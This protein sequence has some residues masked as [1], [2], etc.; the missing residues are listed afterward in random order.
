MKSVKTRYG[1]IAAVALSCLTAGCSEDISDSGWTPSLEGRY[2]HLAQRDF[3]FSSNEE[4]QT[5]HIQSLND[6]SFSGLPTWLSLS[7][8]SGH[9]NSDFQITAQANNSTVTSREAVFYVSTNATDKLQRSLTATQAG[10]SPY[11]SVSS[12]TI[13]VAGKGGKEVVLVETNIPSLTTT[14]SQ[15]WATASYNEGTRAV[16]LNITANSTSSSRSG[17]LT[18][19]SPT[20]NLTSRLT[21]TQLAADVTIMEGGN[22]KYTANGGSQTRTIS[23]DLPWTATSTDSWIEFSPKS[24]DAGETTMTIA[25]LPSYESKERVGKIDLYFGDTKRKY[26]GITQDGRYINLTPS[27]VTVKA[28][29]ETSAS[30]EVDA[31]IDWSVASCPDWLTITPQNGAAGKSKITVSAAENRSLNSRSSTIRLS[32]VNGVVQATASVEQEGLDFGD[33]TT[34]EF[35]WKSSQQELSIPIPS[36]WN[37]AVSADWISLSKYAGDGTDN[38]SVTVAQNDGDAMRQGVISFTSE[39]KTISVNVVQS[40]QYL[41]IDKTSGEIGAMGGSIELTVSSSVKVTPTVE[42]GG[43]A[44]DWVIVSGD[45]KGVYSIAVDYNPSTK[46]REATLVLMPTDDG[47]SDQIAQGVKFVIKQS[48]RG[49]SA[50]VSEISMYVKGGTSATYNITADGNY[51]IEKRADDYWYTLISDYANNSFY[52]VL[53]ENTTGQERTGQI[54]VSLAD[55]HQGDEGKSITITVKQVT[56]DF[57]TNIDITDYDNY[58]EHIFD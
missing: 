31:D 6:W 50:D 5:G 55:I 21:V 34:M 46:S 17:V 42:Y 18:I 57:N 26:I 37:A 38:I 49:L 15:P 52:V 53:T 10:G 58:N 44:K 47:V 51:T 30:L 25:A 45:E 36:S 19:T 56:S 43:D 20:Y 13:Q 33:N 27:A 9:G 11:L 1:I 3:S 8:E 7:K 14:F 4:T 32:S 41:T 24:G 22:L 23:S 40:G 39:G 16:V 28:S 35:G 54:L 48:G 29:G 2:L 12:S